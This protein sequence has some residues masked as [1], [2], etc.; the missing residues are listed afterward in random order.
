MKAEKIIA[1]VAVMLGLVLCSSLAEGALITI[2]IEGVVDNVTDEGNYLEGKIKPGDAITGWYTYDT[3][4]LDSNPI[5]QVA[6][7]LHH[8]AP[9]GISL[10]VGGFEFKTDPAN[11]NFLVEIINDYTSGGLQD[12]Y[13]LIS[14]NNLLLSN[15]V[16]VDSIYWSL[17]DF[18][19]TALSSTGLP[20][21][22]P[23][24]EDWQTNILNIS[25]IRTFGIW[26]HVTSA[27][28]EPATVLLFGL[29][30]LLLRKRT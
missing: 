11:V 12:N 2:Q 6:D 8:A 27:I 21:T 22:A 20:T 4:T 26:G 28:P 19:A 13:G 1:I 7:Y 14:Y 18:S 24:L 16:L 15:G 3:S 25:G 29:G 23:V 17:T 30:T 9:C 5:P 10:T